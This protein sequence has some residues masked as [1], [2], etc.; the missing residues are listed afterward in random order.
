MMLA[1]APTSAARYISPKSDTTGVAIVCT[2][3]RRSPV[4]DVYLCH[5]GSKKQ[6]VEKSI[7]FIHRLAIQDLSGQRLML[8][9]TSSN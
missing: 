2:L 1:I 7:A 8:L 6:N 5:W 4:E 9:T 3:I